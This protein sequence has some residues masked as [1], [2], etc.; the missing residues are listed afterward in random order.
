MSL[1]WKLTLQF[2]LG[3]L[4]F[5]ALLFIPAG[6]LRYW[7]AWAYLGT[8]FVPGLF[9]CVYFYRRDPAL[10]ERRMQRHEKV[11][12][13]RTIM[14]V[15]YAIFAGAYLVPG[16]DYRFGWTNGWIGAEPLS[17]KIVALCLVL[18]GYLFIIWVMDVNRYASRTIR[19]EAEQRV[20][21]TGPYGWVR[22]P[23]YFGILVMM[24]GT[25]LALGSYVAVPFFALVIPAVVLRLLNEEQ[26]L[27]RELVGY[28]EYCE[29]TR[30]RLVP[31]IW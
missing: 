20:A 10:V 27:R 28:G 30:Y 1:G 24:V 14:K 18:D 8:W 15:T 3:F 25:P 5:G 23:M 17:L 16:L 2:V 4:V 9:F 6:T 22:H 31:Y 11:K 19:V 13:Q 26:V 29:R 12:E 21:S 7:E